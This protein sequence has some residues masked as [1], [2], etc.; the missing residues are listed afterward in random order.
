MTQLNADSGE[1]AG[2]PQSIRIRP[3][4]DRRELE[5]AYRL[6]YM[7][8]LRRG[9]I[10]PCPSEMR[11]TVFNA[12]P[13]TMTFVGMVHDRLVSTVTL[14]EDTPV[15][16]PMDEIYH[17]ELQAL[18][19]AGRHPV[20]VTMLADRRLSIQRSFL[21]LLRLMKLVF[22]YSTLVLK[23]N[24]MCITV[25]PHH[26][27]F[28][29]E[30]L[31]FQPLGGLRAYPSVANNPAI[32]RRLDLDRV[33]EACEGRENLLRQFF[34]DRTP[35]K[36]FESGYRFNQDDMRHFFVELTPTL[37]EA[38]PEAIRCLRVRYPDYPWDAWLSAQKTAG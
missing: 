34:E 5:E 14:V 16:L 12:F 6:V 32:G 35:L 38:A 13:G 33:R 20:E 19:D 18:R 15:G 10:Q 24:D 26:D 25:N 4:S 8:Y 37:Q 31:L 7:N 21:M 27:R 36:T 22:D 2:E 9:Y 1:A 28:Y 3:V 23:A 17:E 11:L 30:Y 29:Q